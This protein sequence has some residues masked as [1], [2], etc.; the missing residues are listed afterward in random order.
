MRFKLDPEEALENVIY[1]RAYNSEHQMD[2]ITLLAAKFAEEP[3]KFK[4]LIVDSIISL[5]RSDFSGRGELGERQQKLNQMLSRLT[6]ISEEFN[7]A[8]FITNQ[9]RSC[10]SIQL[11]L[12][13]N[14]LDDG[15]SWSRINVCSRS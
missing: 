15:G 11:S 3:G 8:I 10:M 13:E 7:V 14:F 12:T 4:L 9:V 5:F 6:K 2:L 1:S